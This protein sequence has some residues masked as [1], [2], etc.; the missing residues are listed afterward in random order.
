MIRHTHPQAGWTVPTMTTSIS[1]LFLSICTHILW[2]YLL[3]HALTP[4]LP[5]PY[6]PFYFQRLL[7]RYCSSLSHTHCISLIYYPLFCLFPVIFSV[8][9]ILYLKLP[10][11]LPLPLSLSPRQDDTCAVHSA[12]CH[13]PDGRFHIQLEIT[14]SSQRRNG[15]IRSG[16]KCW[17]TEKGVY[18]R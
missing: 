10:Y 13:S 7:C 9:L 11:A 5:T 1:C 2:S 15:G 3:C 6:L 12:G 4:P 16:N 8:C 18:G 14:I 17:M